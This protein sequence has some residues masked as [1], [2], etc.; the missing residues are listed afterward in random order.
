MLPLD[1]HVL[2]LPPAFTLSQDQ[3]LQLKLQTFGLLTL[4]P[5]CECEPSLVKA[6]ALTFAWTHLISRWTFIHHKAPTQVTCAHCQR[7]KACGYLL[8]PRPRTFRP[9]EP[10]TIQPIPEPSTPSSQF[11]V[12]DGM[13]QTGGSLRRRWPFRP[14]HRRGAHPNEAHRIWEGVWRSFFDSFADAG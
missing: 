9:R 6:A 5:N 14:G 10:R 12:R 2:G 11:F 3:T 7:S 13:E 8:I 1:L 4:L